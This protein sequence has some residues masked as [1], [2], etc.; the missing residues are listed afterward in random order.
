V[1]VCAA[2]ELVELNRLVEA[3]DAAGLP[4]LACAR[5]IEGICAT[6]KMEENSKEA[7][8]GILYVVE[9]VSAVRIG[10]ICSSYTKVRGGR[11]KRRNSEQGEEEGDFRIGRD[12][13]VSWRWWRCR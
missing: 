6:K 2:A 4:L 8:E 7:R 10:D 13:S 3:D 5:Q 11:K 9:A 12:M 1:C